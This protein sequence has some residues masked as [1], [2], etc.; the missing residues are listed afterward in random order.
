[1]ISH[2]RHGVSDRLL[3]STAFLLS[4]RA[5]GFRPAWSTPE[6]MVRS[7]DPSF[8]DALDPLRQVVRRRGGVL[9]LAPGRSAFL[10]IRSQSAS[11]STHDFAS[12]ASSPPES[13]LRRCRSVCVVPVG[14]R[15]LPPPLVKG[16][17]CHDPRRLRS[18]RHPSSL[19]AAPRA[20]LATSPEL[21]TLC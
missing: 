11:R 7:E 15:P 8:H 5:P 19:G 21:S 18:V 3:P 2:G 20:C 13:R 4:T 12:D 14:S 9:T 6:G 1:M 16:A 10:G 17:A